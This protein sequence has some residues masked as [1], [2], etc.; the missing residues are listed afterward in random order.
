MT[1]VNDPAPFRLNVTRFLKSGSNTI[2]IEPFSP[3]SEKLVVY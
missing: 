1:R 2:R 3:R